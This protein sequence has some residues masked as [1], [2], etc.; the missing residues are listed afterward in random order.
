MQIAKRGG[1]GHALTA[2][3]S[4]DDIVRLVDANAAKGAGLIKIF[5]T[6]GVSSVATSQ[7]D[8]LF[9]PREVQ[10][11]AAAAHR[12]GLK[13]AAHAHGG[14]GAKL[15]LENGVDTIEHGALFDRELIA[16]A[17]ERG[18]AIVG[19]FSI[20]D[21]PAGIEAGDSGRPEIVGKLRESRRRVREAWIG[22]LDAGLPIAVGTDSMH[23]CLAFDLARLVELGAS[24]A[25][26]LR[27][28]TCDGARLCGLNDRGTI[29]AGLRA[30][31]VA[32]LGN[33]LDDIRAMAAPV[34]V[35][36]AGHIVHGV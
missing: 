4:E 27:A 6:G 30:D 31:F 5:T 3:A 16:L 35:M 19:T 33:P 18:A 29:A 12:H 9:T 22:I 28:A 7:N 11:A 25:R 13:L 15:A 24:P 2:V 10:C 32:V 23:G 36:K 26:A 8:C 21:H 34:F 17:G 20:L 14:A 1:H